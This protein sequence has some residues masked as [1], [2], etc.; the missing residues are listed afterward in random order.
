MSNYINVSVWTEKRSYWNW[1]NKTGRN[2]AVSDSNWM[3]LQIKGRQDVK[4]VTFLKHYSYFDTC[5]Y[6]VVGN[7]YCKSQ[8]VWTVFIIKKYDKEDI[9]ILLC[10]PKKLSRLF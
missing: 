1:K 3:L 6:I 10:A 8:V 7:K 9:S 2:D 4:H 5:T